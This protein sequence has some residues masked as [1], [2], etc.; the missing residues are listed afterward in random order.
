MSWNIWE[1]LLPELSEVNLR[2]KDRIPHPLNNS[3]PMASKKG[4]Y[5]AQRMLPAI[6]V[7]LT[8]K[9]YGQVDR[10]AHYLACTVQ[11]V[12]A[13]TDIH[14]MVPEE[15]WSRQLGEKDTIPSSVLM[16]DLLYAQA[17]DYLCEGHLFAY[18]E[19]LSQ[20]LC[21]IHEGAV[22]RKEFADNA[23]V[24][25]E[26]VEKAKELEF[27]TLP[28]LSCR[29]T[30]EISGAS[31]QEIRSLEQVGRVA[32]LLA[33]QSTTSSSMLQCNIWLKQGLEALEKLP[34]GIMNDSAQLL[35]TQLAGVSWNE[36]MPLAVE[37]KSVAI[38]GKT[39]KVVV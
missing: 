29:I 1:S 32:G 21:Y 13:G 26:Q 20:A 4:S 7:L 8:S 37:G 9:M 10:K 18:L 5:N 39:K 31:P 3:I 35:L 19:A 6:L 36:R 14:R 16:G 23:F 27:A 30:A 17:V 24:S 28:A 25:D 15:N 22:I 12:Q 2:L 34:T 38:A 11:F 33:G